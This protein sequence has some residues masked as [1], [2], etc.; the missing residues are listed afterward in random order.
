MTKR[1]SGRSVL[2]DIRSMETALIELTSELDA[3]QKYCTS[4]TADSDSLDK[5]AS[6]LKSILSSYDEICSNHEGQNPLVYFHEVTQKG[7]KE[8]SEPGIFY[9]GDPIVTEED[10]QGWKNQFE[11]GELNLST[12]LQQPE[13]TAREQ[14]RKKTQIRIY[15]TGTELKP[16]LIN[17]LIEKFNEIDSVKTMAKMCEATKVL[18]ESQA[19]VSA[20]GPIFSDAMKEPSASGKIEEDDK[21]QSSVKEK[22]RPLLSAGNSES[23]SASDV[24]VRESLD[25]QTAVSAPPS[26]SVQKDSFVAA[27]P[28][29]ESIESEKRVTQVKPKLTI[30]QFSLP[31]IY[32]RKE[33]RSV[34][35]GE[36]VPETNFED[37]TFDRL[38]THSQKR[39]EEIGI[40]ETLL[41][42][43]QEAGQILDRH[44]DLVKGY[45]PRTDSLSE[46]SATGVPAAPPA[47]AAPAA[48]PAPA[49]PGAPPAPAAPGAR[50]TMPNLDQETLQDLIKEEP[51]DREFKAFQ[52][53]G[54]ALEKKGEI[55]KKIGDVLL[56]K[57]KKDYEIDYLLEN[58]EEILKIAEK[59]V[60]EAEK[61]LVH[62]DQCIQRFRTK[63]TGSSSSRQGER[64]LPQFETD[65]RKIQQAVSR[66]KESPQ[67]LSRTAKR[68]K[69]DEMKVKIALNDFEKMKE[70]YKGKVKINPSEANR[71]LSEA[72][73]KWKESKQQLESSL[74]TYRDV[75]TKYKEAKTLLI[76]KFGLSEGALNDLEQVESRATEFFETLKQ[77]NNE[78]IARQGEAQAKQ[79]K[80]RRLRGKERD[81]ESVSETEEA[82]DYRRFLRSAPKQANDNVQ[83]KKEGEYAGRKIDSSGFAE[84]EKRKE[85]N[86]EIGNV[87]EVVN[88]AYRDYL[89]D[90][91]HTQFEGKLKELKDTPSKRAQR[92]A[93]IYECL[94]G[95]YDSFGDDVVAK[96]IT[97]DWKKVRADIFDA[98]KKDLVERFPD[99]DEEMIRK[100]YDN[101]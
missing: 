60:E 34:D 93:A 99:Y 37:M 30:E 63:P 17:R 35:T 51:D 50:Q 96:A 7:I 12:I 22:P 94:R 46:E 101:Y 47:P 8:Q 82:V 53:Y 49:A 66:L 76:D 70:D 45:S 16:G 39:K 78:K 80:E 1:L 61:E 57:F 77:K 95:Y 88:Q 100:E 21:S 14:A 79:A 44:E 91:N 87:F 56:S 9:T 15:L 89:A 20:N 71:Q 33:Q 59:Y 5:I 90:E 98:I 72:T 97:I 64:M 84:R 86:Q 62:V 3:I 11:K 68:I 40:V 43:L 92:S 38:R 24:S 32:T 83:N 26:M 65:K 2:T 55:T 29:N 13:T 48:P 69:N 36:A 23:R 42:E 41:N 75:E 4:S 27:E 10:I 85:M 67:T 81:Q 6:R 74:N 31:R 28:E 52:E 73:K 58:S 18:S 19:L 25:S 54:A